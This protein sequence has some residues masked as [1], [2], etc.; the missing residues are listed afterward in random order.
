MMIFQALMTTFGF[1]GSRSAARTGNK[2]E[3][4]WCGTE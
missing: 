2:V 3:L 1:G 4:R